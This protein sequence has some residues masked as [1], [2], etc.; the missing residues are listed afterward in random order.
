MSAFD[1]SAARR[2]LGR[3]LSGKPPASQ[4]P[5]AESARFWQDS[6]E[7]NLTLVSLHPEPTAPPAHANPTEKRLQTSK[8]VVFRGDG[9]AAT[10]RPQ[11][12][13]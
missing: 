12:A 13:R 5:V 2:Y 1:G 3:G 7:A 9:I 6:I 8:P 11:T 4:T 10:D